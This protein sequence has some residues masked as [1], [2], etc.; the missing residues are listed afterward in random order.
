M[1]GCWDV[2]GTLE[3]RCGDVQ[4]RQAG[5]QTGRQ[6]GRQTMIQGRH[7]FGLGQRLSSK[8]HISSVV[9]KPYFLLPGPSLLFP[10]TPWVSLL[11]QGVLS[12]TLRNSEC[13]ARLLI[14]PRGFPLFPGAPHYSHSFRLLPNLPTPQNNSILLPCDL[15]FSQ[16]LP[17]TFR[18]CL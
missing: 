15:D 5:R 10:L 11:L 1:G 4:V 9:Q 7:Q 12:R 3:G 18:G 16:R 8:N 6:A 2:L 14:T 17:I 13:S